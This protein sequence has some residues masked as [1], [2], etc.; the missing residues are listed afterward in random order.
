MTRLSIGIA[1]SLFLSCGSV[2]FAQ[3]NPAPKHALHKVHAK[4]IKAQANEKQDS[5]DFSEDW[6]IAAPK[7]SGTGSSDINADPS[8]AAGRKKF[9]D[10]STTMGGGGPADS[11][12]GGSSSGFT[13]SM[14]LSF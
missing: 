3:D 14:G 6:S 4:K 11:P 1:A 7:S 2:A 10:Q 8:V 5:D 12:H 13:P 9:F